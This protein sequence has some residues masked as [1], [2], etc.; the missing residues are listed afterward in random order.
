MNNNENIRFNDIIDIQN[1]LNNMQNY[2]NNIQNNLNNM[3][4]NFNNNN[5]NNINNQNFNINVND[6]I[7]GSNIMNN[8]INNNHRDDDIERNQTTEVINWFSNLRT[9]NNNVVNNPYSFISM[10][11]VLFNI[12][13]G[14]HDNIWNDEF[15]NYIDNLY[16]IYE[17]L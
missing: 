2:I 6:I 3:Q 13:F 11:I 1:N 12:G 10:R 5:F 7:E 4:N 14:R 15:R 9:P 8:Y 17:H 16:N